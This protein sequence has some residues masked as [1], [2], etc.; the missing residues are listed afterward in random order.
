MIP[1]ETATQIL[2]LASAEKWPVGTIASQLGVHHSVVTRVLRQNGIGH[3]PRR[4]CPSLADPFVP[5]IEETLAK[6]P[7][8]PA[9]RLYQMVVERGYK[10]APDHFRCIVAKYRPKQPAEAYLRLRTLPG[11]QAQVDWADFGKTQVEGAQRRLYAF[12][13]VLSY[14]R[15]MFVKFSYSAA[16][17]A[18]VRGHV[19]AFEH[20]GG[21]A[22][23][24]QYDNLKS[25]VQKRVGDAIQFNPNLL[26]LA[27]HYRFLPQPVAVARGNEKGR[28]ERA[29]QY[30]RTSFFP[31]RSFADIDDLNAQ[32]RD[33]VFNVADERPCP[34]QRDRKVHEAFYD[35]KPMLLPLPNNPFPTEERLVVHAG[36]SPYIRFDLNDYSIPHDRVRRSLTVLASDH[37]VSIFDDNVPIAEH[38]R[39]WAKGKQIE[40]QAHIQ[41]LAEAKAHARQARGM[42]RLHAACPSCQQFFRLVAQRGGNLGAT[43]V[44]LCRMLNTFGSEMLETAIA[45]AISNQ[46]PHLPALHHILEL[47]RQQQNM[48]PPIELHLSDKAQ[49]LSRP[50][51]PHALSNYD[52]LRHEACNYEPCF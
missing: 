48:P 28:V 24:V 20:F 26:E 11:E 10:G 8:L 21:V 29:I 27:S 23:T 49:A 45:K 39:S 7:R 15:A 5:F 47:E 19:Q 22:R 12:V 18:F 31:A 4:V 43:T 36:K 1:N 14:S 2:R 52:L 50:V 46:T 34:Q 17:G 40:N 51:Q 3:G 13:M 41:A 16:M 42:D 35:E 30:V 25:A 32:A 44:G 9:S 6:H 33:W 38:Q 37:C